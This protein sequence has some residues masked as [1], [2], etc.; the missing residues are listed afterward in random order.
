MTRVCG[1]VLAAGASRRLG[2]PKQLLA[3]RGEPL[4]RAIASVLV[5]APSIARVGVVTG[6]G[7]DGVEAA[8]SGLAVDRVPN[9]EWEEGMASSV[10]AAV[11]WAK[12][13]D[14]DALLIALVDQVRLDVAHVEALTRAWGAGELAAASGYGGTIGV[15]AIFGARMF[16]AL[17][18]LEGDR[19]AAG[20]LRALEDVGVVAWEEG[21]VDVD[22]TGDMGRAGV[23][24]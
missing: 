8:V 11:R 14:A 24:G 17:L 10:R 3:Y 23:G 5:A 16:E 15:P 9:A 13:L 18:A 22:T 12:S 2:E 7:R 20:L 21:V 6:S 1:V 4:V 19:G